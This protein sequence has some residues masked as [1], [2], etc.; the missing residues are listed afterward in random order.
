MAHPQVFVLWGMDEN[1][2][3]ISDAWILD[4]DSVSWKEVRGQ[5]SRV[6]LATKTGLLL[7][8]MVMVVTFIS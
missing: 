3:P 5:G 1:G 8:E 7:Y 4:V 2:D 6:A